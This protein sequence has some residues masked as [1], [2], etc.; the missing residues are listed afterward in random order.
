MSWPASVTKGVNICSFSCHKIGGELPQEN[1]FGSLP[2]LYFSPVFQN[3]SVGSSPGQRST[4]RRYV[5]II[6]QLAVLY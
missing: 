3:F 6:F 5:D 2:L 1:I 4:L